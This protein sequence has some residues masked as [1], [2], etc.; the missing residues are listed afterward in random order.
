MNQIVTSGFAKSKGTDFFRAEDTSPLLNSNPVHNPLGV[1]TDIQTIEEVVVQ[2]IV[3][4]IVPHRS[5]KYSGF[6]FLLG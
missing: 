5:Q 4:H 6:S 1:R 2:D 3:G